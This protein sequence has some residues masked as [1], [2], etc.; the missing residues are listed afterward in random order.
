MKRSEFKQKKTRK[1]A[2]KGCRKEFE[3]RS[4]SARACS[5]DCA[6]ELTT[7]KNAKKAFV[8]MKLERKQD[9]ERK[10]ANK[11][12]PEH[13]KDTE[14]A[15]NALVRYRDLQAGYGCIS[16]G[17]MTSYPRWQAGHLFS[18]GAHQNRRFNLDNI[19]LQCVHCNMH[20]GGAALAFRS[21]LIER[22]G[23]ERVE[24]LEWDNSS[25]KWTIEE[26]KEMKL[27]FRNML[28]ELQKNNG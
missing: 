3:P 17:S 7:E 16:C 23:I 19:H 20:Q 6:I 21:A 25:P 27:R 22:I 11:S 2:F 12:R 10:E 24:A 5:I 4:S 8:S 15:C 14:K 1:C 18:V 26:L 9:K 28:K 13:L